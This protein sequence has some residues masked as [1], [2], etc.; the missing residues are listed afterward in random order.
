MQT[1]KGSAKAKILVVDDE[2]S[3][4]LTVSAI[5]Q[6]EGYDVDSVPGGVEALP[7]IRRTHYD[8]VLTDLK[9]PKVDG[10]AVLEEVRKVSPQSATIMLTGY[11]SLDSAVEA[12]QKGAYEYLVKPTEVAEL[13]LA[14]ARALERKR[15]SEI[16]TLYRIQSA[17][18]NSLDPA[19]IVREVSDAALRVLNVAEASVET[20]LDAQR[21]AGQP[22]LLD[23]E[24][25]AAL[26]EGRAITRE[27]ALLAAQRWADSVGVQ[28]F[29]F[30]PGQAQGRIV[31]V[32]CAHNGADA[33]D[34]HASAMRFLQALA[35]Q[36]ALVLRNAQ[37]IAELQRNNANLSEA[38]R[39][40]QELDRLKSQFLSVATHEL[41][42]PL[43]VILGYNTML[44]ESLQDR[45]TG[46]EHETLQEAVGACK[47]LIRLV[48]SMLDIAQIESGKMKMSFVSSDLRQIVAGTEHLFR[49]DA[50]RRGISLHLQMPARL[51]RVP[52]D[53][54]RI[55]QVLVNL[56]G[57]ALKFTP[58]GGKVNLALHLHGDEDHIEIAVSDSG[59]GIPPEE[60]GRIFDEFAQ[61]S[62]ARR[63]GEGSGLGLAIVRRIVQAHQGRLELETAPGR[64]STFSVFLPL[65]RQRTALEKAVSA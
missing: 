54:E 35:N 19:T 40:L 39:K 27:S 48:N 65:K 63:S 32:L 52:A 13:K 8:L 60:Q 58:A 44:T 23:A 31:C 37:L 16:D 15:L 43:S 55:Q 42:T 2:P 56:V 1:S 62:R 7:A 28:D 5:L 61:I 53:P 49:P 51:P 57:N 45:L 10:L 20:V 34:F 29:A 17:I 50:E 41:R 22:P 38:N 6:D 3:I 47:R 14:V 36:A 9:M 59:P 30:I 24:I 26:S 4:L 12:V 11:G 18:A 64:G 21:G 25:V 33:Y 46:E